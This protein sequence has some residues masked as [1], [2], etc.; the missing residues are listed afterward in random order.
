VAVPPEQIVTFDEIATVGNGTTV[1]TIDPDW[2]WLHDDV[3]GKT[4][5][6]RL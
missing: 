6:T 1:I 3:P 4:T 5:L 2:S